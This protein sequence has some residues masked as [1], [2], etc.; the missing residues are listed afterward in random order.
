L[1]SNKAFLPHDAKLCYA[2]TSRLSVCTSVTL[3]Y[4]DLVGWNSS[5]II[6]WLVSLGCSLSVDLN[7][8]DLLQKHPKFWLE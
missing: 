1:D 3:R 8:T 6:T 5:K 2:I 7:I 4:R